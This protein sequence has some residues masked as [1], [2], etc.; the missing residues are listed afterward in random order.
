[1]A[2][3]YFEVPS[4]SGGGLARQLSVA[5]FVFPWLIFFRGLFSRAACTCV[6]LSLAPSIPPSPH[7]LPP[8][9]PAWTAAPWGGRA[10]RRATTMTGGAERAIVPGPDQPR[11]H[12]LPVEILQLEG[13]PEEAWKPVQEAFVIGRSDADS[14]AN[15]GG[16]LRLDGRPKEAIKVSQPTVC[17]DPMPPIVSRSDRSCLLS[18]WSVR[19]GDRDPKLGI[20]RTPDYIVFY[21]YLAAS[22]AVFGRLE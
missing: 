4:I 12:W 13:Q 22:C 9:F 11:P 7:T 6:P 21:L 17:L 3:F 14:L 10:G 8:L 19:T 2:Y 16:F 5:C 15:F 18:R 1:M 20:R